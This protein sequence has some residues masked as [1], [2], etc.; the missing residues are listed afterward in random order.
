MRILLVTDW[1]SNPGGIEMYVLR[2]AERL[3]REGDEVRVLTSSAGTGGDGHADYVAYASD[4]PLVL[5]GLQIANPFSLAALGRAARD[6]S[7][8][9]VYVNMFERYLSPAVL[10]ARRGASVVAMVQYYK[11]VCPT[12]TKLLPGGGLCEQ[13][14][15]AVCVRS[16]CIGWPEWLRDRPR[17][18]LIEKGLRT[19]SRVLACSGW[20]A[21]ELATAGVPSEPLHLPVPEPSRGFRR[22]P[23][24]DPLIL[25]AGRLVREKG[26]DHL[27]RAFAR[28]L[29]RHPRARLRLVGEGPLE[30]ALRRL[31]ER[32]ELG[33]SVEFVGRLPFEGVEA[34]LARA[35]AV[36]SPSAWAEPLG[37]VAIE[38]I[39]HGAPVVASAAGGHS[40]TIEP[41]VSGLLYPNGDVD[42]LEAALEAVLAGTAFPSR[43]VAPDAVAR[44]RLAHDLGAHVDRLRAVFAEAASR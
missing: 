7:P 33:P 23:A 22:E 12:A 28:V 38:A 8:E 9:I 44:T 16:G 25:F 10:R 42:A 18:A 24:S 29:G 14:A 3:A 13:R 26:V 43:A 17:Y 40:E 34:E 21:K 20:V 41:G 5:A 19:C 6:F 31:V 4:N 27:L 11:P 35:W 15:G 1:T 39:A 32:L 37:L 2:I 36:V 30:P